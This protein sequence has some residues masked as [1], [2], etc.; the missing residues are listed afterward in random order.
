[1]IVP[2]SVRN[3]L[4]VA[5]KSCFHAIDTLATLRLV[6]Y[7]LIYTSL[8]KVFHG[9]AMES[10]DI[11]VDQANNLLKIRVAFDIWLVLFQERHVLADFL[12]GVE[13]IV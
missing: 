3:V 12:I 8:P 1:M 4:H 7:F 9:L 13:Q 2:K 11:T 6:R 5:R 10:K